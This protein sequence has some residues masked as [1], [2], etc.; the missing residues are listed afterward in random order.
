MTEHA[1]TRRPKVLL[2]DDQPR[3]LMAL[4]EIL[5]QVEADLVSVEAAIYAIAGLTALSGLVVIARMYETHP[6]EHR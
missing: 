5:G 1:G 4:E 2:V 3:N 6:P